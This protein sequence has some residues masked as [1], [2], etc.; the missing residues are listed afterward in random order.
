VWG[1]AAGGVLF[2]LGWIVLGR[3]LLK[4]PAL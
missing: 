4:P 3:A 1:M 2:A